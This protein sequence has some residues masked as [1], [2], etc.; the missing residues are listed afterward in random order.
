MNVLD[1]ANVTKFGSP[2]TAALD[3]DAAVLVSGRI[4]SVPS[5]LVVPVPNH[6]LSTSS[7]ATVRPGSMSIV[8]CRP[9]EMPASPVGVKVSWYFT[10]CGEVF[11]TRTSDWN[12]E[13]T[14]LAC[15]TAGMINASGGGPDFGFGVTG[16]TRFTLTGTVLVVLPLLR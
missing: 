4:S 5:A 15:A 2:F 1:A 3:V 6:V 10:T 11:V 14:P 12:C 13:F 7:R 8:A 9:A 16:V